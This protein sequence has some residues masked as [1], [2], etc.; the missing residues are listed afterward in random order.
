[1]MLLGE[2]GAQFGAVLA[3]IERAMTASRYAVL[4]PEVIFSLSRPR[5]NSSVWARERRVSIYA[6]CR[7]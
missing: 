5:G 6:S 1:M 3:P 2:V 4:Q 7:D